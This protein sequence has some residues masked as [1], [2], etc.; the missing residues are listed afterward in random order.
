[1]GYHNSFS[2]WSNDSAGCLQYQTFVVPTITMCGGRHLHGR[3]LSPHIWPVKPAASL[4]ISISTHLLSV[5]SSPHL[6]DL[7]YLFNLVPRSF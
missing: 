7:R 2:L 1:M 6:R 4:K 5:F 3:I